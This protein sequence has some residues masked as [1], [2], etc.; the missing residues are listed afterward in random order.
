M[1]FANGEIL[2]LSFGLS[3]S[4]LMGTPLIAASSNP[5]NAE[6]S[7]RRSRN[8]SLQTIEQ[9]VAEDRRGHRTREFSVT[10]ANSCEKWFWDRAFSGDGVWRGGLT[11]T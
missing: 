8:Q 3:P 5:F 1:D 9:E 6:I 11:A 7:A 4:R 10:S 2:G